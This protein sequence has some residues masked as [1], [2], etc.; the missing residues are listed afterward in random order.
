[1]VM[2]LAMFVG[3]AVDYSRVVAAANHSQSYMDA[4]ALA[5][6]RAAQ[7][8]PMN[9]V[10]AATTAANSY[11]ARM[12]TP[13]VIG[14]S[15]NITTSNADTRIHLVQTLWVKTPFMAPA[16]YFG[17]GGAVTG[18][19]GSCSGNFS[20][21]KIVVKASSEIKS[22][23]TNEGTSLE[24]SMMLD[25]TGSMAGQKMTD[26]KL[27]AKDLID[28][29]VWD[30]QTTQTYSKVAIAPFSDSVYVGTDVVNAIGQPLIVN[31]SNPGSTTQWSTHYRFNSLRTYNGNQTWRQFRASTK[32]LTERQ[33]SE[34][35]TD[36]APGANRY[37]ARHYHIANYGTGQTS[38]A[39][40]CSQTDTDPESNLMT[41]LSSDKTMLKSRIDKMAIK[42]STAGQ[43]GTA[44]AWY[45]LSP[46]FMSGMP[47][48]FMGMSG[49]P[50]SYTRPKTKKIA[51]LMTDGEYNT[52][53]CNGVQDK[54][55][56]NAMA[57]CTSPNGSSS[58]QATALCTAMKAKGIEVY[59][60]GFQVGSSQRT[61]LKGCATNPTTHYYD[62]S[63][64]TALRL[65]F[66]DIA[67]KISS[68]RLIPAP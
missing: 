50:A 64:G 18:A 45:L 47:S 62:A 14:K 3:M 46:D 35:F 22:G 20:C 27:A 65:A 23:G 56:Y 34:R 16:R 26:L 63:N 8:D 54:N 67:L 44:W 6:A 42:G 53:Y 60:I 30:Q 61:L 43:L 39:D 19:P 7:T 9:P 40:V 55:A 37:L 51:I 59:S 33:G 29:V 58:S 48:S 25:V 49:M 11:L 66:R 17:T 10:G 2:P 4:A 28:I 52:Q 32:C 21:M 24:V 36:A 1:M 57:N 41:A 13:H 15:V 5:A 12:S 31:N 38:T 68:I